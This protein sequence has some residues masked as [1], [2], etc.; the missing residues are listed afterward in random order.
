MSGCLF[1]K[2]REKEIP[3]EMVYEGE[4]A[5]AFKDIHPKAKHHI[6]IV[7]R[8]HIDSVMTMEEADQELIGHL[9]WDA[10]KIAEDLDLDGYRLQFNCGEKG[11]QIIFHIHLHLM[12][13]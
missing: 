5:F 13:D 1:C 3:S 11:G 7:P 2:I 9:I 8:K 10:K 12:A 4:R 6:L